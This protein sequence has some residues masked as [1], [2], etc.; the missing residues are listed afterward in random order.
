MHCHRTRGPQMRPA[1]YKHLRD[2][3]SAKTS[4]ASVP[5]AVTRREPFRRR[6]TRRRNGNYCWGMRS[7]P[8]RWRVTLL[9]LVPFYAHDRAMVHRAAAQLRPTI[10]GSSSRP[11]TEADADAPLQ[12]T[13]GNARCHSRGET[14][15]SLRACRCQCLCTSPTRAFPRSFRNELRAFWPSPS[16]STRDACALSE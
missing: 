5:R 7:C 12:R 15:Q 13:S 4:C 9:K 16:A 8:R 11:R 2:A 14:R 1:N 6:H 3:G 10:R